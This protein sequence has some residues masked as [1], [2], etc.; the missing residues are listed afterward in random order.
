[1]VRNALL[2]IGAAGLGFVVIVAPYLLLNLQLT[3]GLLPSTSAAKQAQHAPLLA[4][5]FPRRVWIM[6]EP[7]LAGGQILLLPGAIATVTVLGRRLRSSPVA[8]IAWVL[9]AWPVA[10]VMLYAA[11]L[12]AGYQHGRYVIPAL[13]SFIL[14]GTVGTLWLLKH[15]STNTLARVLS[16]SLALS[17]GLSFLLMAV[18]IGPGV[19]ARDVAIIN[20]E[21]V[22]S[23]RWL[24]ANIAPEAFLAVHDIGAVAYFTP[25]PILD[26]A[27]N[28]VNDADALWAMMQA[29]NA[30]YLM[31][32]PDQIPG[33]DPTDPRLCEV[34]NTGG[35]AA[36]AAGGGNM[37]VYALAWDGN[38][39]AVYIAVP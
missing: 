10:L 37:A 1:M 17:A 8:A 24:D 13:P 32:F 22:A 34:F 14:I 6:V 4:L 25:R 21:M 29:Q 18:V 20:E 9:V 31:A 27:V 19:L 7:L 38:C 26:I 30:Q 15:R 33:D 16:R 5:S 12:P 3:G 23:A 39:D 11:R 28:I 35:E 36:I 2:W